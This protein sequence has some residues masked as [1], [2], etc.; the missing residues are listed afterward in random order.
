MK[1]LQKTLQSATILA[2]VVASASAAH[3]ELTM[4]GAVGLP[5]N[6]TAQIPAKEAVQVQANFYNLYDNFGIRVRQYGAY[7]AFQAAD[8][9]ELNGGAEKIDANFGDILGAKFSIKRTGVA[10]GAKYLFTHKSAPSNLQF[11]AGVGYSYVD[12]ENI[13]AYGVLSKA[14]GNASDRAPL[15]AHLGV[16]YDHFYYNTFDLGV[17]DLSAIGRSNK[18]SIYG[19][20]EIPFNRA[21]N[22]A[23]VGELQSKVTKFSDLRAPFSAGLRLRGNG[24]GFSATVG[25]QRRPVALTNDTELFAQLGYAFGSSAANTDADESEDQAQSASVRN[26]ARSDAPKSRA[27]SAKTNAS[28]DTSSA[29]RILT[30]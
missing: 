16:R 3:A 19:G 18:A 27:D 11:A 5:L 12:G 22:V 6:P 7:A 29:V 13:Y 17:L 20:L 10:V 14:F 26:D 8:G 23:F 25:V 24:N 21:G 1:T 2:A 9:L 15:R 28:R 4:N 30:R